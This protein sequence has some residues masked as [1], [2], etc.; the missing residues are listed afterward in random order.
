MEKAMGALVDLMNELGLTA[1]QQAKVK[2]LFLFGGGYTTK[3]KI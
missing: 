2:E 3:W 1:A